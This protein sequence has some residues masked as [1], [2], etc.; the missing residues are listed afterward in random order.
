MGDERQSIVGFAGADSGLIRRFENEYGAERI[1]LCTNY[2]SAS[3]LS[4]LGASVAAALGQPDPSE[5]DVEYPAAGQ[6]TITAVASEGL[7]GEH[8]AEWIADLLTH[9]LPSAT[10]HA[11]E[12]R[13]VQA[14]EIAVLGR[15]AAN[16]RPT[17]RTELA[18]HRR[19]R[20][21][22]RR[23]IGSKAQAAGRG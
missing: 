19:C 1:E 3:R 9:G 10:L 13:D 2:R 14:E 16:L 12:E 22:A 8:V 6:V 18:G 7:E 4:T 20:R 21:R 5:H 15:A 11:G 23:R 17:R